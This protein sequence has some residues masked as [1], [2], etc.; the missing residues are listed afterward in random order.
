MD[1]ARIAIVG[2]AGRMGRNLI[3]AVYDAEGMELGAAIERPDSSLLGAD[4]GELAGLGKLG[5]DL[6]DD[7]KQAVDQFD[8]LIDFTVPAATMQHVAICREANKAIVIGTTGLSEAEKELLQQ[9]SADI[10]I[11]F[12]P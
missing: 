2:A 5:V 3:Q 7:L 1:M 8:V 4:A 6:T 9:A 10:G 11:M 12:A